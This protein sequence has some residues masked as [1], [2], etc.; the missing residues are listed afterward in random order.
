MFGAKVRIIFTGCFQLEKAT[1]ASG[2]KSEALRR[3]A[4]LYAVCAEMPIY[5][6]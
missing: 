2:K 4:S 3:G 6:A 5:R 1:Q